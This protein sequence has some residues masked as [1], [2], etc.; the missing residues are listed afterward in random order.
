MKPISI[1]QRSGS[2]LTPKGFVILDACLIGLVSGLAAVLLRQGVDWL[3][4]WRIQTDLK[5]ESWL[6]LPAIGLV[7]GFLAGWVVE[8]FAS[9]ASG[10]GVP[11]VKAALDGFP[12]ALDGRVALVK[13]AGNILALGS[14]LPLGRQGPTVQIGAALAAQLSQWLPTSPDYQRQLIACGAAAGLAAG[15][16]A[17]IAAVLFA[18]EELL[19]DISGFTLGSTILAA[20]VG[21]MV[22]R[23]LGG[24]IHN[25]NLT[26]SLTGFSSLEI[27]FYLVLGV[28]AGLLGTLFNKGILASLKFNQRILNLGLPLRVALAGLI[29]GLVVTMLPDSVRTSTGLREFLISVGT[30]AQTLALVFVAYFVLTL[31]AA[32]SGAPGGLFAPTIALGAALGYLVGLWQWGLLGIEEPATYAQVGMGAL[33]CVVYKAPITGVVI[34]FE[35]TRDFNLVLPLMISSAVAYWVA[36]TLDSRSLSEHIQELSGLQLKMEI[37]KSGHLSNLRV[38]QIMSR[39]PVEV[40]GADLTLD[41]VIKV[42]SATRRHGFP[43]VDG[44]QLVGIFTQTD[45]AKLHQWSSDPNELL[46]M[47]KMPLREFMTPQPVTVSP[48]DTLSDVIDLLNI[49]NLSRLPVTE[50]SKLVGMIALSDIIRAETDLLNDR[51]PGKP[52]F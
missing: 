18:A 39:R 46:S 20:F 15:F 2:P 21:S 6:L 43:V 10:S 34:V 50:D 42:F 33:F 30:D 19:L 40:L 22:A 26:T 32:G 14:G 24:P 1:P 29:C 12:I 7:G 47:R 16:N 5:T 11:Q 45:L 48:A 36:D 44:G 35:I 31:I 9:E 27:P 28:L 37:L 51:T 8:R 25:L 4:L 3:E 17:P 41:E 49:Q 52:P 13:L 38:A 23:L